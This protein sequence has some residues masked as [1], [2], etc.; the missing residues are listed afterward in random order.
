M[1]A[2][3]GDEAPGIII[4]VSGIRYVNDVCNVQYLALGDDALLMPQ[5][6]LIVTKFFNQ[7]TA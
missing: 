5:R 6:L 2:D 4:S 7:Y 3:G 1:T